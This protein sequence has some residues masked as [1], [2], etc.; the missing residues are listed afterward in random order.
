MVRFLLWAEGLYHEITYLP[1]SQPLLGDLLLFDPAMDLLPMSP[2]LPL[3]DFD[4]EILLHDR[5]MNGPDLGAHI[6]F[7]VGERNGSC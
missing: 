5:R 3:P 6:V 1:S 2:L 7:Q 4:A